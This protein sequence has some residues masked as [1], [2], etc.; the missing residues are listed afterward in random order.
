MF[1]RSPHWF[2]AA[3][4][5][6]ALGPA[7]VPDP[8]TSQRERMLRD[9]IEARGIR[10]ADVLRA[11][12]A[13][14]RH[15]FVPNAIRNQAYNDTALPIGSGST[16]SQPYIVALMT[17]LLR[18][19]KHQRILEIGTG[20]GYQAAVLAQLTKHVYTIEIMPDL[21]NSARERLA[22]LGYSNVAVRHGDGYRGWPEAAPF[23]AI[24]VTAAPSEIPRTLID[25]LAR[26]GRLVAPVGIGWAQDLIVIEKHSD[27][28]LAKSSVVP[29]VFVPMKGQSR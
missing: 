10:S 5:L 29:V 18:P 28:T 19:Q 2:G 1:R 7:P 15:L 6:A 8:Y 27:G 12:R 16:I 25:Q 17:E 26:G 3:A 4:I 13:T 22:Q 11:L 24:I 21:A 23:D 20:S 14:P 9:Q